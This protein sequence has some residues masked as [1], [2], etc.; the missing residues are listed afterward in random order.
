[1]LTLNLR[2]IR[3]ARERFEQAYEPA[4]VGGDRDAYL[5]TAPVRLAMDVFKDQA[6][7]RLVGHVRT[8]LELACGRCLEPFAWPVEM[9][10]DLQY[11]PR[12]DDEAETEREIGEGDFSA[13]FY[14]H[15][16]IDLDQLIGEQLHLSLPMKPLC[17]DG[18]RGL[19]A[20]CGANLNRGTCEC[21]T[22]WDDPRLAPL[23]ALKRES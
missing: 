23:R 14:E 1:M 20:Q 16:M 12:A 6:R 3:T 11:Q 5:I 19:C 15:E 18:C 4:A 17:R 2:T 13:A 9:A 7:F 21:R 8:T 10:F 22:E